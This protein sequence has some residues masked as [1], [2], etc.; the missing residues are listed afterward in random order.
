MLLQ[1]TIKKRKCFGIIV[2]GIT[3]I[4]VA[5]YELFVQINI[6]KIAFSTLD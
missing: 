5:G 1:A 6:S 4:T 3:V 2:E